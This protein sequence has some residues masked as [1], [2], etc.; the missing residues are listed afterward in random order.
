MKKLWSLIQLIFSS[1]AAS[2]C[3]GDVQKKGGQRF[4][5]TASASS[6]GHGTRTRNPL[7]GI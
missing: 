2:A 1:I 5:S 6:G 3:C 4:A 7:R